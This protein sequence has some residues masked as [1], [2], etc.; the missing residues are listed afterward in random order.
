MKVYSAPA[1]EAGSR[2]WDWKLALDIASCGAL[3]VGYLEA[4]DA[5][6]AKEISRKLEAAI[7]S[8]L[9]AQSAPIPAEPPKHTKWGTIRNQ[10]EVRDGYCIKQVNGICFKLYLF[11]HFVGV[12]PTYDRAFQKI[13]S[14]MKSA[15][16]FAEAESEAIPAEVKP[17]V[18]KENQ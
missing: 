17:D 14:L 18:P 6:A 10:A 1:T 8:F 11:G 9:A 13:D 3:A 15:K 12:E 16:K 5:P 4:C 2:Q 7:K